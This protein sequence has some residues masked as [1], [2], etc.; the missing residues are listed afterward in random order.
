MNWKPQRAVAIVAGTPPG[1]GLDRVAR[2]LA[3]TV[4]AARLLEVA[5][6]VV[7]IPGDGA[8]RAWTDYLD[9]YA[10]DGHVIGISSPNLIS[11]YLVGSAAFPHDHYTSIAI[12]VTEYIAFAARA[13]SPLQTGADL[14]ARLRG[15]PAQ[16]VVALA[17]ALGNPNHVAL[18]KL[19]RQAGGDVNAPVL[20]VFNTALDAIAEVVAGR[21]DVCAVTAASV[22]K[23]LAAGRVRVLGI[24]S[25]A[26]LSGAF[27]DAPTWQEQGA[28][29]VI[30]AWRGVIGPAGLVPQVVAYWQGVLRAAM[31]EPAWQAEL[32]RLIW[33]PA[34]CD[35]E[36]L[37]ALLAQEAAETAAALSE[38]GLLKTAAS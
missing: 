23:E 15:A 4:A 37:R 25:P 29:C 5:V 18:A 12:L 8:R 38:F 11:D 36:P 19:T 30:G 21:A 14:L 31:Q 34:Y 9:R 27:A 16:T 3:N 6:E 13:D 22:L 33:S 24:S 17:T 35:G 26:R 20:R 2:A 10:G 32:A 7:N 28:D 1:G